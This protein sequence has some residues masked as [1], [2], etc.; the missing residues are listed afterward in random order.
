MVASMA[1]LKNRCASRS[2]VSLF[3]ES[4]EG[5]SSVFFAV[6]QKATKFREATF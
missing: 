5:I 1:T 2:K 4:I 6:L 3:S